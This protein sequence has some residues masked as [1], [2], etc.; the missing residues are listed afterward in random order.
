MRAGD[1]SSNPAR[2]PPASLRQ[3]F[4]DPSATGNPP[5]SGQHTGHPVATIKY[6]SGFAADPTTLRPLYLILHSYESTASALTFQSTFGLGTIENDQNAFSIAPLGTLDVAN[7]RYWNASGGCCDLDA[8]APNDV[9]YLGNLIDQIIAAGWP[10]D[11]HRIY[12]VG[13][14]NGAFMAQRLADER[15]DIITGI[16]AFSGAAASTVPVGGTDAAYSLANKV[17]VLEAHGSGDGTI[18]YAGGTFVTMPVPYPAVRGAG[19]ITAPSANSTMRQ[20]M[21]ADGCGTTTTAGSSFDYDS[22]VVGNETTVYTAASCPSGG[23][24]VHW[25][26]TGTGHSPSLTAAAITAISTFLEANHR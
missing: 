4:A 1:S 15:D 8:S 16:A 17:A 12:V 19:A 6:P 2:V 10:V 26:M 11:P 20:W 22:S 14:S 25:E 23:A 13:H 5:G 7:E 21:D 18:A 9:A 3:Q 24:F